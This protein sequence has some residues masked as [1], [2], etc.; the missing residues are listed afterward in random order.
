MNCGFC[1]TRHPIEAMGAHGWGKCGKTK[2]RVIYASQWLLEHWQQTM[3]DHDGWQDILEDTTD[4]LFPESYGEI[5]ASS[6]DITPQDEETMMR[7]EDKAE[8]RIFVDFIAR[9]A[10]LEGITTDEIARAM[11]ANE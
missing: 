8:H 9:W 4:A 3:V 6:G 1:C 5:L 7:A 10:F 2:D 11:E